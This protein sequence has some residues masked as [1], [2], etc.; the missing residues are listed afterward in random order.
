MHEVWSSHEAWV[1]EC[2][3]CMTTWEEQYETRHYADGHG[4]EAVVYEKEGQRCMTP[5]TDHAC[6]NCQSQN[7][8]VLSAPRGK[9]RVMPAARSGNDIAMV[10]HLRHIHAF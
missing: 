4:G 7:I 9:P 6:P 5:W 2:L 1:Y 8:K 10:Y 3:A